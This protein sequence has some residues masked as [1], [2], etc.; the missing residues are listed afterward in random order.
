MDDKAPTQSDEVMVTVL[1]DNP[2]GQAK[3][4]CLSDSDA[5]E[6]VAFSSF[7][8]SQDSHLDPKHAT[9][10]TKAWA[11]KLMQYVSAHP[12]KHPLAKLG[13]CFRNLSVYGYGSPTDYQ[14]TV[15]N[16]ILQ[17]GTLFRRLGGVKKRKISILRCFD[18][19]VNPG[20]MLLVLGR[21]GSGCSSLLK[22][23]SGDMHGL[24]IDDGSVLNYQGVPP[25]LL[26]KQ[27][28]GEALYMAEIDVHFPQMTVAQTLLFAAKARAPPDNSFPET[29][30]DDFAAHLSEVAIAAF[31]LNQ[32]A[33]TNVGNEFIGGVSGGERKRVSIAEALL[34]GAPLH[35]WDNST[36]GLDSA[37]AI[38]FCKT[39]RLCTKAMGSTAC[40]ALYQAPQAAYEVGTIFFHTYLGTYKDVALGFLRS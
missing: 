13:V 16:A 30:R 21:P 19:L 3:S 15:A 2:E 1:V 11:S 33:D 7:W 31:G 35:C 17:L 25:K 18:G 12:Q 4:T 22:T 5:A 34:S 24:Y 9:F 26:H 32:V 40:V 38:E 27:F 28:R 23:I 14:K 37:N 39:L 8:A 36:R 29:K 10:S 20:E 6:Q